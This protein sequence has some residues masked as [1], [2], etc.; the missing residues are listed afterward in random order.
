MTIQQAFAAGV[1]EL[2]KEGVPFAP[3]EYVITIEP[4]GTGWRMR[5]SHV[6]QKMSGDR[7]VII[8]GWSVQ[9]IP[10]F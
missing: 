4:Y 5:Y 9:V 1:D 6:P 3:G 2:I 7:L 8:Q 10:L